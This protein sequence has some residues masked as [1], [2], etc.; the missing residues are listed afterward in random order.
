M[1]RDG[2]HL[3]VDA[4]V[5][6]YTSDSPIDPRTFKASDI[7]CRILLALHKI[8]LDYGQQNAECIMDEYERQGRKSQLARYWII[9]MQAKCADKIVYRQRAPVHLSV[10]TDPDDEKYI[11]VAV[12]SPNKIILSEDSDLTS[13]ADDNEVLRLGI[14]IWGF[15]FALGKL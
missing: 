5:L 3:V 2:F 7:L 8:V 4:N 10:L 12:N 15:D 6:G 9:A 14:A 1:S 13:I 11:Q